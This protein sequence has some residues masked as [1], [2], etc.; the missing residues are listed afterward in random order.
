MAASA[1]LFFSTLG[2][3]KASLDTINIIDDIE[4]CINYRDVGKIEL[5]ELEGKI[6]E[7][8][9]DIIVLGYGNP[10][11][12]KCFNDGIT[13]YEYRC[14]SID[15]TTHVLIYRFTVSNNII[16][17]VE[18]GREGEPMVESSLIVCRN[19]AS[20][21]LFIKPNQVDPQIYRRFS[22]QP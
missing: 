3:K 2:E 21:S 11:F 14:L 22:A 6:K 9:N 18:T 7:F 13:T 10:I 8:D 20:N 5:K 17:I 4:A 1:S 19:L 15:D 12:F 16:Q